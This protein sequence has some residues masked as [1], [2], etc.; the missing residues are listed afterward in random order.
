MIDKEK[1]YLK[2][3]KKKEGKKK[4]KKLKEL[5]ERIE[6]I[7]IG[8]DYEETYCDLINATIDYQNETQT[9]NFESIFE[10]YCD[11]EILESQVEYNLKNFGVWAVRNLLDDIKDECGI[12]KIDAYGYGHDITYDDL[13]DI[14][15]DI[16][17][18]IEQ[19]E[20]EGE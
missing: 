11:D 13:K 10:D 20:S 12:Y 15:N 7:E 8:Y 14:K 5:K 2:K 6:N 18:T 17:E 16:L 3:K 1:I 4:M 19:L 9:W